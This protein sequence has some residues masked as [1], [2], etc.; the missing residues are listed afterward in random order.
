MARTALLH[1]NLLKNLW[2]EAVVHTTY[3][4][5][6]IPHQTMK[7][8][9]HVELFL[10]KTNVIQQSSKF[11]AFGEPIWIHIPHTV[12]KLTARS[13]EGHIIGYAA[14][15]RIYH[16]Y[17]KDKKIITTKEPHHR[18]SNG[19]LSTIEVLIDTNDDIKSHGEANENTI[20]IPEEDIGSQRETNEN[21]THIP[22]NRETI[23]SIESPLESK[24]KNDNVTPSAE[25]PRQSTRIWKP[26]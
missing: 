19:D 1:L 25:Q 24:Q 3:T 12:G 11:R 22:E 2:P 8:K 13:M 6:Q 18:E 4:K 9:S 10:P 14:S 20:G 15:F 21:T 7:G 17:T 26:P 5:N 16:V 23:K